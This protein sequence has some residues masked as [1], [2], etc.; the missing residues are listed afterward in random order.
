MSDD[1]KHI[2]GSSVCEHSGLHSMQEVTKNNNKEASKTLRTYNI[3]WWG[4]GYYD[5]NELG[6]ISVCSNPDRP[7]MRVDLVK[8]VKK[9]E[10]EGQRLPA[11]FFIKYY[12]IGYVQLMQHLNV[13]VNLMVIKEIIF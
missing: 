8:L 7:E 3:A 5:V 11:L 10:A 9:R 1:I 2:K 6:H 12:N 13:H 4:N